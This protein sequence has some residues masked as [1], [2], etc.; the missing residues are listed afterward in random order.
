MEIGGGG[1]LSH[2]EIGVQH[3]ERGDFEGQW[4]NGEQAFV[5]WQKAHDPLFAL[6][7]QVVM[8]VSEVQHQHL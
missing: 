3:F 6:L 4:W 8:E 2:G 1:G 5:I 7:F